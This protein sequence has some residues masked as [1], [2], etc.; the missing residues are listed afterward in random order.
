MNLLRLFT[1]FFNKKFED[2]FKRKKNESGLKIIT[3]NRVLVYKNFL[4]Y[5]YGGEKIDNVL[6]IL[7]FSE[8]VIDSVGISFGLN[9]SDLGQAIELKAYEELSLDPSLDYVIKYMPQNLSQAENDHKYFVFVA[10][11]Q[12]LQAK[13]G[14]GP[15]DFIAYAPLIISALFKRNFLP[16]VNDFAFVYI[17]DTDAFV[18]VYSAGTFQYCKGSQKLS[19]A[20][21]SNKFCEIAGELINKDEFNT[22][23]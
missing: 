14:R 5:N 11:T 8:C 19:L 9:S 3:K 22:R 2:V 6:S 18:A 20:Y 7:D 16:S 13:F 12:A 23:I 21:L 1:D 4:F 10:K 17:D 15:V